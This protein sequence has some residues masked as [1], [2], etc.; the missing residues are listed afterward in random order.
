MATVCGLELARD[1]HL[2]VLVDALV[3]AAAVAA[4]L[5]FPQPCVRQEWP[6]GSL[7]RAGLPALSAVLRGVG[8]CCKT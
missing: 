6:A 7:R 5:L 3:A 2:Q 1:D 4:E 8:T